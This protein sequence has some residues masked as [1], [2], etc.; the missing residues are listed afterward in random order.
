[1]PDEEKTQPEQNDNVLSHFERDKEEIQKEKSK[2]IPMF[3][4]S[5]AEI[6]MMD[7]KLV[8]LKNEGA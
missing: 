1:M 5:P 8:D 6:K 7:Q 4:V 2:Y 3:K